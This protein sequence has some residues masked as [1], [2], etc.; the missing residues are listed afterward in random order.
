MNYLLTD[1]VGDYYQKGMNGQANHVSN[2]ASHYL[3]TTVIPNEYYAKLIG[4]S[5]EWIY[6][7]SG[8][9]S[10]TRAGTHENTNTMS[11]EA[12]KSIDRPAPLPVKEVD[13]IVGATYTPTTRQAR[14]PMPY[15]ASSVSLKP[16]SF[17][18]LPRAL[19]F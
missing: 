12:T 1:H 15:S 14:W 17:P 9:R 6:K 11:V 2:A 10:R 4:L 16:G 18:S 8:I 19:R 3:P 13:L 7:R 5:D